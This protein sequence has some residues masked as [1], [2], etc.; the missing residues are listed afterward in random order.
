MD[1]PRGVHV[2]LN[3][4][5]APKL[6]QCGG[7]PIN[8]NAMRAIGRCNGERAGTLR[9]RK[10]AELDACRGMP[11]TSH[12]QPM[13]DILSRW[14]EITSCKRMQWIAHAIHII[15]QLSQ[16]TSP[17]PCLRQCVVRNQIEPVAD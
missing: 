7:I 17:G 11:D 5:S 6:V 15:E 16:H 4:R 2:C 9:L 13:P 14:A 1:G 10:R 8:G 3:I 12:D